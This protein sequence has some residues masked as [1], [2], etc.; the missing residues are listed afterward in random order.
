MVADGNKT[1]DMRLENIQGNIMG[2][3]NK[4]HQTFLFLK[5][6]EAVKARNWL[7]GLI[8]Q[9][10]TASEVIAFNDLFKRLKK[11]R[12]KE[13]LEVTWMNIAFS[14]AGLQALNLPDSELGAFPEDFRMGMAARAGMIGD[15]GDNA[16]NRWIRP[17]RGVEVHA[18]LIVAGDDA[19]DLAEH[20]TVLRQSL[21]GTEI[22]VLY[23]QQGNAR[24]DQ[25]GHEHFGFDDGVSQPGVR[26]DLVTPP[27]QGDP[28]K[29]MPGQ[30]R[31]WPGEFVLGYPQQTG[32]AK[33]DGTPV[34]T[35]GPVAKSGP[36]WT[37]DGSYLVF[38]RLAQNV[39]GFSD[40]IA[41]EA[42]AH[43]VTPELFGAKVVGRYKSGCPLART[44]DQAPEFNTQAEDPSLKD[45]SM[46]S[47]EKINNF[48]FAS[49]DS[50]RDDTKGLVLPRSG[51]IRKVYPRNSL[52]RV[53]RS[54]RRSGSCGGGWPSGCPTWMVRQS[55]LRAEQ[56][57][58]SLT[59]G[60][61]Y[62]CAI[63]SQLPTSSSS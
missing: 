15:V 18:I 37:V 34:T 40:F 49:K 48:D 19:D 39:K 5:F 4:D 21:D 28:D 24:V 51:H 43:G 54:P 56:R 29:G 12:G 38:R 14:F 27:A 3:F 10:A 32:D 2:G 17:L 55:I 6:G 57:P 25:P 63:S 41:A 30:D 52:S 62:S 7:R 22:E 13:I 1:I 26:N 46:L 50:K 59:T 42:A 58:N 36:R 16:P 47:D 9:V 61:C 20:V 35:P 44:D 8:G 31:L 33:P 45:P 11:R 60:G 23:Q 53:S